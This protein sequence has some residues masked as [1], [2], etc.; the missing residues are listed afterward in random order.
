MNC[1]ILAL[2]S[3]KASDS[4]QDVV[5]NSE[6]AFLIIYLIEMAVKMFGWLFFG[7]HDGSDKDNGATKNRKKMAVKKT[8]DQGASVFSYMVNSVFH[9]C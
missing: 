5:T 6:I 7:I 3:P 4:L 1:I 9:V 8:R 2:D